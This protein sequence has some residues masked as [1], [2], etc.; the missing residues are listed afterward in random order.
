[1]STAPGLEA[2]TAALRVEPETVRVK[3]SVVE[4]EAGEGN[5]LGAGVTEASPEL[6]AM[7]METTA[8]SPEPEDAAMLEVE[9]EPQ[10]EGAWPRVRSFMDDYGSGLES[11]AGGQEMPI[12]RVSFVVPTAASSVAAAVAEA[13]AA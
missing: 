2:V 12:K 6:L 1:M 10:A 9:T 3:L 8:N 13:I 5:D 7:P 11:V 4:M